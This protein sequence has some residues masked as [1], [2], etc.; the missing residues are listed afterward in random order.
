MA[1]K[2]EWEE[3]EWLGWLA[4]QSELKFEELADLHSGA[5]TPQM[6]F[7][8]AM[9]MRQRK[10]IANWQRTKISFLPE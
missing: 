4:G 3:F 6:V 8:T 9:L 7:L 5:K 10:R 2:V 1:R